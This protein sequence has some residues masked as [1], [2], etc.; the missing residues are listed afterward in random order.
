[1]GHL[2]ASS[3]PLVPAHNAEHGGLV[4]FAPGTV[5]D[6]PGSCSEMN[7]KTRTWIMSEAAEAQRPT[8]V[9]F[10]VGKTKNGTVCAQFKVL[11]TEK[12]CVQMRGAVSVPPGSLWLWLRGVSSW[13]MLTCVVSAF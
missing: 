3:L 4:L 9:E 1:M 10:Q 12:D 13:W 6:T 2:E 7:P 11:G 5:G 8:G